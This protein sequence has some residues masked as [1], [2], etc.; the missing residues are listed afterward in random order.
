MNMLVLFL[1]GN[2]QSSFWLR[3]D[4]LCPKP[5]TIEEE[6]TIMSITIN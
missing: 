6:D 4:K 1:E 5:H 2:Y 3:D